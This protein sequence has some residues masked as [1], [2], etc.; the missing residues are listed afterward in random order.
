MF[1]PQYWGLTLL[2]SSRRLWISSWTCVLL[3]SFLTMTYLCWAESLSNERLCGSVSLRHSNKPQKPLMA[4]SCSTAPNIRLLHSEES[5]LLNSITHWWRHPKELDEHA[6]HRHHWCLDFHGALHSLI[7]VIVD[8]FLQ[9][10]GLSI[11]SFLHSQICWRMISHHLIIN[12]AE[13][14]PQMMINR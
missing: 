9:W 5:V 10:Q 8:T 13:W 11:I 2:S 1:H 12:C 4:S 3:T 7:A 14:F 6:T